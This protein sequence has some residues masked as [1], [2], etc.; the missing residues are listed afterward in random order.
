M[1][2]DNPSY[3]GNLI[4]SIMNYQKIIENYKKGI[5]AGDFYEEPIDDDPFGCFYPDW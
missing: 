1:T 4:P 5:R 2:E 3:V